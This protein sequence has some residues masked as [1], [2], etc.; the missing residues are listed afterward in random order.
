VG[1]LGKNRYAQP[2]TLLREQ[3]AGGPV[4]GWAK[5]APY[6]PI[7]YT[8]HLMVLVG[9]EKEA[10]KVARVFYIDPD[11]AS[12]PA[13]EARPRVYAMRYSELVERVVT[14]DGRREPHSEAPC[15][16]LAGPAPVAGD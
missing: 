11:D 8:G 7:S 14:L 9:C 12:D 6:L 13:L 3:V 5:S 15:Y 16:V 2:P 4:Y 1:A 10:G